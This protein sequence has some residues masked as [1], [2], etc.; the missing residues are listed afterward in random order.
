MASL[1]KTYTSTAPVLTLRELGIPLRT[2]VIGLFPG[3]APD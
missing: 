2:P 1:T 3:F